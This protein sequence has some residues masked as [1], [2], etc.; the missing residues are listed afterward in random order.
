MINL[1]S[2]ALIVWCKI[3]RKK[4]SWS[5]GDV[6]PDI[7]NHQIDFYFYFRLLYFGMA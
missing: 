6:I 2:F 1:S 7:Q 4:R 5:F 3:C